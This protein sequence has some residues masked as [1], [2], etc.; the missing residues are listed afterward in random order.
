MGFLNSIPVLLWDNMVNCFSSRSQ[1]RARKIIK[2][3][4]IY[5]ADKNM[6]QIIV[7]LKVK[8]YSKE[9]E[10]AAK[11]ILLVQNRCIAITRS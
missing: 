11:C 6:L 3:Q 9:K 8:N 10:D 1:E 2:G 4:R 5:L 7:V